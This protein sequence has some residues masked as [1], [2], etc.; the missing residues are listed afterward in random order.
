L[1][2]G[3]LGGVSIYFATAGDDPGK[4]GAKAANPG[5]DSP[6]AQRADDKP[7][8][9]A[10]TAE[11]AGDKDP[12]ARKFG[13]VVNAPGLPLSE[14]FDKIEDDTELVVRVDVAAFR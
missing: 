6:P 13:A 7:R 10:V 11:D 3:M 4:P 8:T 2:A 12:L 5:P 14:L 9:P 1:A